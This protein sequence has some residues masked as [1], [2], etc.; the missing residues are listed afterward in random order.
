MIQYNNIIII[1]YLKFYCL[2]NVKVNEP[3]DTDTQ[4]TSNDNSSNCSGDR[5]TCQEGKIHVNNL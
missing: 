4:C 2:A 5:C 1:L 3:C